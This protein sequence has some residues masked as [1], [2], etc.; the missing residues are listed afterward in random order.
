VFST[1]LEP[2]KVIRGEKDRFIVKVLHV[3]DSLFLVGS[4]DKTIELSD[5]STEQPTILATMAFPD[6]D[7][8]LLDFDFLRDESYVVVPFRGDQAFV[9]NMKTQEF[10]K[11][12]SHRLPEPIIMVQTLKHFAGN[13]FFVLSRAGTLRF[14]SADDYRSQEVAKYGPHIYL[15]DFYR[16]F[17]L[18]CELENTPD[19]QLKC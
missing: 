10:I 12:F 19:N 6:A 2:F 1:V 7:G 8:A 4:A 3:R 9:V 16:P 13:A 5:F 11:E 15:S 18:I 17:S 14:F